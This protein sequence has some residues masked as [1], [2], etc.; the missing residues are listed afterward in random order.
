MSE[1]TK[2][3]QT[4]DAGNKDT[5]KLPT[6]RKTFRDYGEGL[7]KTDI[8]NGHTQMQNSIYDNESKRKTRA[9]K[10]CFLEKSNQTVDF[11]KQINNAISVLAKQDAEEIRDNVGV[12]IAQNQEIDKKMGEALKALKAAKDKLGIVK[13]KAY[14]LD[15]ARKNSAFSDPAKALDKAYGSK[16]DF[17]KVVEELRGNAEATHNLSD[18]A[19]EVVVKVS[20]IRAGANIDALKEP[21]VKLAEEVGKMQTDVTD[22]ITNAQKHQ[23]G[24]QTE[25][26]QA[27]RDLSKSKYEKY[28]KTLLYEA[29]LDTT[30]QVYDL[31]C[32]GWDHAQIK[33]RLKELANKVEC[34]FSDK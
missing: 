25:Y 11:Y 7:L 22:N 5:Q 2:N 13:D 27:L 6:M 21:S 28:D 31:D 34:N 19:L 8:P 32:K 9:N 14:K 30:S 10:R 4:Q 12:Y 16:G 15:E 1:E 26:E 20:G 3:V 23:M 17:G 33:S 18:D 29:V 24:L